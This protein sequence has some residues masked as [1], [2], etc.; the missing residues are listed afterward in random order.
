[1]TFQF[2]KN[3]KDQADLQDVFKNISNSMQT[4]ENLQIKLSNLQPNDLKNSNFSEIGEK[5]E[6]LINKLLPSLVEDYCKLTLEYRNTSIIKHENI[7]GKKHG[8]TS[9]DIFLQNLGKLIEEI[10]V[11][12]NQFNH[13]YS[14]KLLVQS[15]V[16]KEMGV[17][18]NIIETEVEYE[19]VK[20]V[21]L[22]SDF[23]YDIFKKNKPPK[24][25][26]HKSSTKGVYTAGE[27]NPDKDEP[28]VKVPKKTKSKENIVIG[29]IV[30]ALVIGSVILAANEDRT[31]QY[32]SYTV[33]KFITLKE[34]IH[35]YYKPTSNNLE[36]YTDVSFKY[37]KEK[38]ALTSKMSDYVSNNNSFGGQ[39][40]VMPETISVAN[41][42]FSITATGIPKNACS[43]VVSEVNALTKESVAVNSE[44]V[45]QGGKMNITSVTQACSLESN[46]IKILTK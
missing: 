24:Q 17:H 25:T 9:K 13:H 23:N 7:Q 35:A 30:T 37:V 43:S 31:P 18:K 2:Y 15:R 5:V 38:S 22:T 32:V 8:Y 36:R 19:N 34:D 45:S 14:N 44:I 33:D 39:M 4:L 10:H 3:F 1:M 11:L 27:W 29:L 42:S 20:P 46:T 28:P 41:D 16:V 40:I 6:R 21:K 12:E 26:Q